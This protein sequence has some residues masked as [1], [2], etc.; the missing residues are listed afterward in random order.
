[1]ARFRLYLEVEH[2]HELT[3]P[4]W[5][6]NRD[7]RELHVGL[8]DVHLLLSEEVAVSLAGQLTVMTA[9]LETQGRPHDG[10]GGGQ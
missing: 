3:R 5:T 2:L 1:V 8:G 6:V 9:D 7:R 4:R 10:N